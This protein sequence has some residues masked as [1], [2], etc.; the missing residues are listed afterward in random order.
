MCEFTKKLAAW[1]DGELPHQ[2]AKAV[3]HHLGFCEECRVRLEVYRRVSNAFE[4][5]CDAYSETVMAYKPRGKRSARVIVGIVAAA[6]AIAVVFLLVSFIRVQRPAASGWS[7]A[8]HAAA[9]PEVI[10]PHAPKTGGAA[11]ATSAGLHRPTRR[12][13]KASGS[14]AQVQQAN[15]PAVG[16]TLEIAVPGDAIFAPGAF[17]DGIGFTVD[18]TLA[19]DG[20][21][22][23]MQ[24]RPQLTE[25]ERRVTEP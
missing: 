11:V 18:V 12:A 16:P 3:E 5:Y 21:A 19:P 24:V 22:Q 4:A 9:I 7:A 17:P 6:A 23:Q 2:D 25:F 1:L 10:S 15:W 8:D 13:T 14:R 20:W